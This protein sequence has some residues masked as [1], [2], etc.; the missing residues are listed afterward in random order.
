M[1]KPRG[2][3]ENPAPQAFFTLNRAS[4][5]PASALLFGS[6]VNGRWWWSGRALGGDARRAHRDRPRP[7]RM[8]CSWLL[9]R[10]ASETTEAPSAFRCKS[11][12]VTGSGAGGRFLAR[13][14]TLRLNAPPRSAMSRIASTAGDGPDH[15]SCDR[16]E[17]AEWLKAPHSKCGIRAT[18]SGV[19]IPPSPPAI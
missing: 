7:T 13:R 11:S 10:S 8:A 19:R 9:R 6:R 4:R 2:V 1:E 5:Q 17:V 18:V 14:A 15:R 3:K 12:G 16:G